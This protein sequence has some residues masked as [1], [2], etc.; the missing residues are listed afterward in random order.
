MQTTDPAGDNYRYP[1]VAASAPPSSAPPT[2]GGSYNNTGEIEQALALAGQT[3]SPGDKATLSDYPG[4]TDA[5]QCSSPDSASQ[6]TQIAVFKTPAAAQAYAAKAVV[7]VEWDLPADTTAVVGRNWVLTTT[8]ATYAQTAQGVLGGNLS[9]P[10]AAPSPTPAAT[11]APEQVTF[12]CTGSAP[13]GVDI[14]YGS[15]GSEHSGSSLPFDRVVPLDAGAQYYVVSAQ[16]QGSGSVSCTTTVQTDDLLGYAQ[17]VSNSGSADGG[18]NIASAQVCGG[19]DG[20][21]KC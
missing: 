7:G 4:A 1:F 21:E 8:S 17:T 12:H 15:N 19:I 11:P 2:D 14:T 18:Y 13:D 20:W 3:C 5:A 6:D 10:V 16:L 9:M